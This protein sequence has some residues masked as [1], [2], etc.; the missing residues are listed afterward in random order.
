ML[1]LNI[2][3]VDR[4]STPALAESNG[5]PDEGYDIRIASDGT[6][7]HEGAPIG[8]LPLV[9][10]FASVLK[11]DETGDF[12]L[13]TP[14]E[15]GRIKVEDAPFVAVGMRIE[16]TGQDQ[17]VVFRTNLDDEVAAGPDHPIRIAEA[18][19][20]GEPRPYIV[21]RDGLEARIARAVFYDLVQIATERT[22]PQGVEMGIWSARTFFPLGTI[23]S[24]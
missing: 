13:V 4:A 9:K 6:W 24:L 2:M 16:G 14:A 17:R 18:G 20:S 1:H 23:P 21:V 15:R 22:T 12:W 3:N 10:L 5:P 7:F 19:L 8:R 11:R